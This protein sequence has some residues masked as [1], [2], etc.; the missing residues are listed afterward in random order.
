MCNCGKT[1]N[2]YAPIDNETFTVNEWISTRVSDLNSLP[3]ISQANLMNGDVYTLLL[4][5]RCIDPMALPTAFSRYNISA[6]SDDDLQSLAKDSLDGRDVSGYYTYP[7]N[8]SPNLALSGKPI[9]FN[10]REI[11]KSIQFPRYKINNAKCQIR[12]I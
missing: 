11:A 12:Y 8:F 5:I 1:R 3:E 6:S 9:V 7:I 4:W 2:V 10:V